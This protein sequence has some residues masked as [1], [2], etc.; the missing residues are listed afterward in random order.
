MTEDTGCTATIDPSRGNVVV[1]SSQSTRDA[2]D[3]ASADVLAP[4]PL[5][6]TLEGAVR[7]RLTLG[8]TP[9][10]QGAVPF[11]ELGAQPSRVHLQ[12]SIA[13]AQELGVSSQA[14]TVADQAVSARYRVDGGWQRGDYLFEVRWRRGESRRVLLDGQ[15]L[16]EVPLPAAGAGTPPDRLRLGILRMEGTDGGPFS[17]TMTGWQLGD[18]LDTPLGDVQ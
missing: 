14:G 13:S 7:G 11:L 5:P 18:R 3:T 16:G 15:L 8:A 12:L 2:E 17:L 9:R 10:L 1:A 6:M 4:L